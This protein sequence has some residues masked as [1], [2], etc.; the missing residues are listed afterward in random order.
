MEHVSLEVSVESH[1]VAALCHIV[2]YPPLLLW[3]ERTGASHILIILLC[4]MQIACNGLAYRGVVALQHL[5]VE[6][7]E[8]FGPYCHGLLV[9]QT[10]LA[11]VQNLGHD[12]DSR[13]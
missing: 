4:T 9:V 11:V 13:L 12:T 1:L 7:G 10:A 6:V 2:C 8:A 5:V 3:G